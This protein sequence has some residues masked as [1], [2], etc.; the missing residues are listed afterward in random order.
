MTGWQR[1]AV[2]R[3]GNGLGLMA[4]KRPRA[5]TKGEK[6]HDTYDEAIR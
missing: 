4:A 1:F 2:G 5:E 3:L 6:W